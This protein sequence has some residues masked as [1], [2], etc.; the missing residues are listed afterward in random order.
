MISDL[1]ESNQIGSNQIRSDHRKALRG[2][3]NRTHRASKEILIGI[4]VSKGFM[5]WLNALWV[6]G[7]VLFWD[8]RDAQ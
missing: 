4:T 2:Y 7:G 1:F 6:I 8:P 5:W 3:S